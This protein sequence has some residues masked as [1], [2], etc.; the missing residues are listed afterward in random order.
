MT[1]KDAGGYAA[2]HAAGTVVEEKLAEAIRDKVVQGKIS[3]AQAE[4]ISARL[5]VNLNEVGAAVDLLEI[6][7]NGCQLGLFGYPKEKFP[8]GK[9]VEAAQEVAP[10]VEAAIRG[11]LVEGSLSCKAAWDIA[12]EK[13]MAKLA[14]ASACENLKIRIRPCQLGAF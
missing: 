13:G 9:T 2:K 6:R 14:V 3:C 7:I 10:D 11:R 8:G 12:A 4:K 1:H 5:G